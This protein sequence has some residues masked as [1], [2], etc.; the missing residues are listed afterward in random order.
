MVNTI[1]T[2]DLEKYYCLLNIDSKIWSE[3]L[4]NLGRSAYFHKKEDDA[5]AI[6]ALSWKYGNETA[7]ECFRM[8]V[9]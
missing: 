2:T 9:K 6:W 5:V 3:Y 8:F 4:L 7:F 1:L